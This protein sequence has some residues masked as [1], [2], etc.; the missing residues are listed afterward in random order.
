MEVS[1]LLGGAPVDQ[2]GRVNAPSRLGLPFVVLLSLA[3]LAAV[4][5]VLHDL[6]V[7]DSGD[8][9]TPLLAIGPVVVWIA[10]AVLW[11]RR[12][13]I[14]LLATGVLYGVLLA[15]THLI[16]WDINLAGS[17]QP[18]LGGTLSG[19][20]PP[21]LEAALLRV[22]AALSSIGLGLVMGVAAGG[23]AWALRRIPAL[24]A[25]PITR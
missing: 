24:R 2:A 22:A 18:A 13:F 15:A 7:V 6:H 8:L 19:V 23:I 20:L 3:A 25:L 14:S 10:V 5:G 12:P 9:L 16:L 1:P 17:T 21:L 4:R 11:S